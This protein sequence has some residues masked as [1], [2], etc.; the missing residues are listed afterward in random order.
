MRSHS[1]RWGHTLTKYESDLL[2][3]GGR[4]QK[5]VYDQVYKFSTVENQWKFM[6][7]LDFSIYSHSTVV[8]K[9]YLIIN[10]GLKDFSKCQ[11]N[12]DL[13]LIS[14][15]CGSSWRKL[16]VPN[17]YYGRFS[18]TSHVT[19]SGKI[20]QVGGV[21]IDA[22]VDIVLTVIEIENN[23]HDVFVTNYEAKETLKAPLVQH[24]SLMHFDD[25]EE[26]KQNEGKILI[27]GGGTNCFSFGMHVN[28]DVIQIC[29]S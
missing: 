3:I 5:K 19:E 7:K 12:C 26:S 25:E 29:Y 27:L 1:S 21:V 24:T 14:S 22:K 20:L 13:L 18:H 11:V 16:K 4:N 8:W 2:L 23:A 9:D 17:H 15:T 10:G 28:S 6:K